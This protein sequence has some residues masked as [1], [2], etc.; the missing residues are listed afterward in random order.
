MCVFIRETQKHFWNNFFW[1]E[2]SLPLCISHRI[3]T[4]FY[5][6][7]RRKRS[8][9]VHLTNSAFYRKYLIRYRFYLSSFLTFPQYKI[10]NDTILSF[11][12]FYFSSWN[13]S[14]FLIYLHNWITNISKEFLSLFQENLGS[15][16]FSTRVIFLTKES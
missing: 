5:R 1:C 13:I 6:K 9:S 3:Y 8:F 11:F 7:C 10:F 15:I 2:K 14:I 16:S 4:S 12:M